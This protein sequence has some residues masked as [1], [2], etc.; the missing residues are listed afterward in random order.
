M[1][2]LNSLLQPI[3]HPF[4]NHSISNSGNGSPDPH[5]SMMGNM[6]YEFDLGSVRRSITTGVEEAQ[7]WFDRGL[8]WTYGFNHEE[9]VSCF[10]R[11]TEVDP[12][13]AMAHWGISYALGPNYNKP[14]D[15]FDER[16]AAVSL[17]QAY[18]SVKIAS[19]KS[20]GCTNAEIDLIE[21]LRARYPSREPAADMS[22]WND[23][24]AAA[25]RRVHQEHPE[26]T[27]IEALFAEALMNRT[28]WALWDLKTGEVADGADTLEARD[29]LEKAANRL[30]ESGNSPHPGILHMYIHLMEMSQT[31]ELALDA[32]DSLRGLVPDSGHLQHMA[33][34]IDSI[35]GDYVNVVRSNNE[36]VRADRRYLEKKGA[37]NFYTLY[38]CHNLHF[39]A[40]GAMFLG[41]CRTAINASEELISTLPEELLAVES[42]PMADWVEAFIPIKQ[43]VLIRFGR[44]QEILQ[45]PLPENTDLYCVT[46]AMM[47]YART[48]AYASL[49]NSQAARR[50]AEAFEDAVRFVPESRCLFNN[51]CLDILAIAKA[52]MLGE[53][54][55]REGSFERAFTELRRAIE[56]EDNLPYDEPWGWM[57]PVRHALGALLIERGR[58]EEACEVYR[59]DLGLNTKLSRPCQHPD[60]IWSLAGYHECLTRLGHSDMAKQIEQRLVLARARADTPITSSC[61]CRLSGVD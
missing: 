51:S 7:T 6:D 49:S 57:Q 9:A 50:E 47:L 12:E 11:A 17:A 20:G 14:W 37:L 22:P 4:K 1:G 53:I 25:M 21:A 23:A 13:C 48:I 60:N 29:V 58:L 3:F 43:H 39:K 30:A 42:P 19:V 59:T 33:T 54:L 16:D 8:A 24:Y 45:Q 28:P 38:R 15:A 61:F 36:A 40:Y 44:W 56:M 27:D 26:D 34:H 55:Y 35:C 2:K 52:M 46:N 5:D 31:P 10:R 18:D 32:A 41:Q